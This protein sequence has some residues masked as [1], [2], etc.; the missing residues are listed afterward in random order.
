MDI[1]EGRIRAE[2]LDIE[3]IQAPLSSN[4]PQRVNLYNMATLPQK[5]QLWLIVGLSL[6]SLITNLTSIASSFHLLFESNSTFQRPPK[7]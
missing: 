3:L 5:I 4:E 6:G 7:F 2:R 1:P